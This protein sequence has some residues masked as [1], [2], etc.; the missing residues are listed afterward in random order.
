MTISLSF[1]P[2]FTGYL[3]NPAATHKSLP[4]S[5]GSMLAPGSNPDKLPDCGVEM[6]AGGKPLPHTPVESPMPVPPRPAGGA[7]AKPDSPP[8]DFGVPGSM[9]APGS[10][11]D[12]L[13][14]CGVQM[15]V[16]N[17]V[18]DHVPALDS[19]QPQ[20]SREPVQ[21]SPHTVIPAAQIAAEYSKAQVTIVDGNV[22]ANSL[23]N[24][25]L[26]DIF[27]LLQDSDAYWQG[28]EFSAFDIFG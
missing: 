6:P 26:P 19:R 7:A 16:V 13:P 4:P 10:D 8:P 25:S 3:H 28:H 18:S 14:G 27:K 21:Q 5:S 11:V 23:T 20:Q 9:L 2:S 17:V 24:L 15:P 12:K 1:T 22:H